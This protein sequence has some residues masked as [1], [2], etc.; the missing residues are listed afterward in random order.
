[1]KARTLTRILTTLGAFFGLQLLMATWSATNEGNQ[2]Y[3][4]NGS[5][6]IP[7]GS[8]KIAQQT[9]DKLNKEEEKA[10]NRQEK[11]DKKKD[12]RK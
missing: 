7:M 10:E 11:E 9:A 12:K 6:M 1:M 5:V 3:I 2:A 4:R 8:D